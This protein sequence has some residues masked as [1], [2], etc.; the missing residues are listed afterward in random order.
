MAVK[1]YLTLLRGINVGGKNIIKMENL[2]KTFE[3]MHY[4]NVKTYI[5]SG[6]IIFDSDE[7]DREKLTDTIEKTLSKKYNYSARALLLSFAELKKIIEGI[8][9][10]FGEDPQQYRYDI[11]FLIPP[12]NAG[13]V[14]RNISVREGVDWIHKGK[15]AVYTTRLTEQM[16]KSRF[17]KIIQTPMYQNITIRNWNTGR[18][19]FEL[20]K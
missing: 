10:G 5:Q 7:A 1:T 8:P 15:N 13:E 3:E 19:L 20:M 14:M 12:L 9:P 2:K 17:T 18:K 16:G 6:N 11:W 4:T